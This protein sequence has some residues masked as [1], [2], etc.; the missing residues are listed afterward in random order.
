MKLSKELTS[1]FLAMNG[2]EKF[3]EFVSSDGCLNVELLKALY[4]GCIEESALLLL[5]MVLHGT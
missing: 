4:Y 2:C 1:I 5:I 3:R